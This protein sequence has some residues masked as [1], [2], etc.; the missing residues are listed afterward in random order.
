MAAIELSSQKEFEYTIRNG[1]SIID[2]NAHWCAPCRDQDPIF[3]TLG[4]AF[5]GK[6]TVAKVNIDEHQVIAMG[7]NIQSIPTIIIFNQGR[8]VQRFIG[9]QA[10]EAL[11]KALQAA[12]D[13]GCGEG[14]RKR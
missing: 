6:A 3:D 7:L 10:I 2:F 13:D 8:E 1:L 12:L 5:D 11:R 14:R 9:L 4:E